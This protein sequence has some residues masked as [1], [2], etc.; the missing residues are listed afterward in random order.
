MKTS[1]SVLLAFLGLQS[2]NSPEQKAVPAEFSKYSVLNSDFLSDNFEVVLLSEVLNYGIPHP[3]KMF[4]SV[5]KQVILEESRG[6]NA[7]EEGYH[8][9]KL[10]ENANFTDSIYVPL[11]GGHR[12][13]FINEYVVHINSNGDS[14][15]TTWPLNGDKTPKKITVVNEDLSWPAD[16][17]ALEEEELVQKSDYH[18]YDVSYKTNTNDQQ[19]SLQ[20]LFY[21]LN[22]RW[23]VLYR[24]FDK[25]IRI[26]ERD[27]YYRYRDNFFYSSDDEKPNAIQNFSLKY[28]HKEK[29]LRYD[30]SIGGGSSSFSVNG[31]VGTGYFNIPLLND[32]LKVK[33]PKL[34]V[35]EGKSGDKKMR[36]YLSNG[37]DNSVSPFNLNIFTNPDLAFA[38][39]STS[40][41]RVYAIRKKHK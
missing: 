39:Y 33:R 28:Y 35:E 13:A 18:F 7:V 19:W 25:M 16:K 5:N 40:K 38:I 41:Y 2:C 10:D 1:M 32:T 14:D 17:V 12:T 30:H 29:K 37:K 9:F 22:G 21:C 36:F 3:I 6:E 11:A 26:D 15:Y 20:K 24:G 8:Y 34:I 4:R 23:Q 27:R 31:W